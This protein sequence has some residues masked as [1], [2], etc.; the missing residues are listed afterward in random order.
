MDG[1]SIAT[2]HDEQTNKVLAGIEARR[3]KFIS[4]DET[5]LTKTKPKQL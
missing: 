5:R 1:V 4:D 2:K 3:L